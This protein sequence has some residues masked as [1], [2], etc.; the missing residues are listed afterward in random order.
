M[1]EK[2]FNFSEIFHVWKRIKINVQKVIYKNNCNPVVHTV[3]NK[4]CITTCQ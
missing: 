1:R 3:T 4:K 2:K